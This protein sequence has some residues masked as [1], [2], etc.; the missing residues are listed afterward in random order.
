MDYI[1]TIVEQ[2]DRARRE[3]Q[4]DHQINNRLSLILIDNAAEL[5]FHDRVQ[6]HLIWERSFPRFTARQRIDASGKYLDDKL[7]LLEIAGDL[8]PRER[9][10]ICIAHDFRNELYHIGLKHN[11]VIRAIACTYAPL[12]CVLFSRLSPGHISWHS[13]QKFTKI[14]NR[15]LPQ[16]GGKPNPL[17]TDHKKL[18]EKLIRNFR[19]FQTSLQH[20]LAASVLRNIDEVRHNLDFLVDDNPAKLS[21]A[22]IITIVQF[23]AEFKASIA[24]KGLAGT[25]MTPGYS[26]SVR[27]IRN[28]LEKKW[29]QRYRHV[30]FEKWRKRAIQIEAESDP[31]K[32][33]FLYKNLRDDMEYLEAAISDA[34]LELDAYIQLEIDH[35]RGK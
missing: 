20:S 22:K 32:A 35:A 34:A 19:R 1:L 27:E 4:I 16:W 15:Y 23:Q 6:Y 21:L 25:W 24:R 30:P 9:Q 26:A 2:L 12:V 33:L 7:K 31:F 13:D 10:F 3:L 29:K 17:G 18:A 14:A 11:D 5:I 28:E 8:S